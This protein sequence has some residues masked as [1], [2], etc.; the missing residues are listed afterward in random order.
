MV[1]SDGKPKTRWDQ[2]TTYYYMM[3]VENPKGRG[4]FRGLS[5]PLKYVRSQVLWQFMEQIKSI[6]VT[7]ELRAAGSNAP[8]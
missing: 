1:N 2:A 8:D 6:T 5:G 7:A 4:K 3:G